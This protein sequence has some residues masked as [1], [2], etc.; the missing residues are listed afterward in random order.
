[1]EFRSWTEYENFVKVVEPILVNR[2]AVV[3]LLT[4]DD[5][6]GIFHA[7]DESYQT[8]RDIV[9]AWVELGIPVLTL[10]AFSFQN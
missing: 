1:M 10:Y 5:A 7:T 6:T 2:C 3:V 9:E 4:H 8:V